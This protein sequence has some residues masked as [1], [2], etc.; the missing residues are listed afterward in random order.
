MRH[1]DPLLPKVISY[2]IV[3]QWWKLLMERLRELPLLVRCFIILPMIAFVIPKLHI[4]GHTGLCSIL[5]S[6]NLIPGSSQTDSEGI[7]CPWANIGGIA[8]STQ[9]MGLGARHDMADDHWG[10]WNW[11]K[12]ISLGACHYGNLVMVLD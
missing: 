12:K 2:D 9:I 8:S 3:C 4:H 1:H 7:E 11:Q 5:Y 10:H 6:L